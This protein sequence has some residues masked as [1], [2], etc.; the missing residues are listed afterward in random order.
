MTSNDIK[1]Q[2]MRNSLSISLLYKFYNQHEILDLF[3]L[4]RFHN[5]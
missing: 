2:I 1:E 4:G 5:T 3:K